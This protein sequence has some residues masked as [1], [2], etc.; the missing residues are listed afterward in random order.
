MGEDSARLR[1]GAA[2]SL[3]F[4][5][6]AYLYV[7]FSPNPNAAEIAGGMVGRILVAGIVGFFL[8]RR[9]WG[10]G[11]A[12][13]ITSSIALSIFGYLDMFL[14][15]N[16][17]PSAQTDKVSAALLSDVQ[18]FT[19]S[20]KAEV[21]P[22]NVQTALEMLDGRRASTVAGLVQM[23]R[24]AAMANDKTDKYLA[25]IESRV[26]NAE[27]KIDASDPSSVKTFDAL[28]GTAMV[29]VRRV[30]S[31]NKAYFTEIDGLLEFVLSR[32]GTYQI[33]GNGIRFHDRRDSSEYNRRVD[34]I[35][36]IVES[37]SSLYQQK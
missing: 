16:R 7:W 17:G 28:I 18:K 19:E 4:F 26:K 13:F 27:S 30:F 6:A 8:M 25:V 22:L 37:T 33:A 11:S 15:L 29:T 1:L 35:N 20:Y 32:N 5:L 34:K 31:L 12:L 24:R 2:L 9:S 21:G 10:K 36:E 3:L 14:L 23:R